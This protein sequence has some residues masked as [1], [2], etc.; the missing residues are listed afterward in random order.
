MKKTIIL[1]VLDGW[2]LGSKDSSNP[3]YIAEPQNINF[4]KCHFP[5]TALQASGIAVGLPWDEEGNSEVG[6]LTIGA[7]KII[8][9][10]YPRISM[11]IDNGQFFENE[12]LKN[13]FKA[14]Q[15]N[16]SNVHIIGLLTKGN[17]HASFKHLIAL[18]EMAYRLKQKNIYLHLFTDGRDSPPHSFL[19]LFDRLKKEIE[20]FGFSEKIVATI[21]GRYY[22]L[23]REENWERT[24]KAYQL[25][26]GQGQ[27][28]NDLDS[29]INQIYQKNLDDEFIPPFIFNDFPPVN[30]N[31]VLIFFNFREDSIR[32]VVEPFVNHNFSHFPVKKFNN[33]TVVTF[34]KY[35]EDLN[36]LVAFPNEKIEQP[37]GKILADNGKIQLRIAETEKYA[38]VT[39]FFNGLRQEPFPNEYR[40]LIPSLKISHP[41]EKPE[42]MA[43]VITDRALT[44]L[45]EGAFDF[46]LINYANPDIIAHTGNFEATV[47]AIKVVDYEVG[48]LLKSVLGQESITMIITSDHGNAEK[49]I[50]LKTGEP[51]TKH[52]P[53]PVPFYFI[54]KKLQKNK[55]QEEIEKSEKEIAGLLTDV[56]PT[57]LELMNIKKPPEMT[58]QSLLKFLI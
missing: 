4:I 7:G 17:V 50:D 8:Y 18:V 19:E 51:E 5:A 34:T 30:D 56:A 36:T 15:K 14:S 27:K 41:D 37:L 10:H 16:Q 28:I 54:N 33:L 47:A 53:N 40:I 43:S 21:V 13:V 25:L 22:G 57:I 9:Q 49:L 55:T 11:A 38:H 35:F 29:E 44:A 31:D 48:R 20:K 12:V 26:L 2:G 32:Q 24:E 1:V 23:N 52:N 45:N 58:G 6:H 42:M 3:I 39:Y 46:I